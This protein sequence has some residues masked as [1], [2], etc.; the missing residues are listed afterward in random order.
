LTQDRDLA[1]LIEDWGASVVNHVISSENSDKLAEYSLH[2]ARILAYR[3]L[4]VIKT[5][6][7][8]DMLGQELQQSVKKSMPLRP[9]QIIE[10]INDFIFGAKK[11]KPNTQDYYNPLNSYLNIVLERRT[12]I[13][14]TL[15]ILYIQIAKA[16]NFKLYP[17]NFPAHFL[18]KHVME[19][20]NG[21]I[22]IDPF[23]GG[24]IMDDYALKSLLDQFYPRQNIPMTHAF[25][26]KATAAQVITRM[27]NNLKASYYEAQDI[28]RAEIS[29]EMV[30]AI[31]KYNPDGVRDKGMILLKKGRSAEALKILNSY[32]EL[33]PNAND[34]D[35]ILDIIRQ[36]RAES[37]NF[38]N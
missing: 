26:E 25:V 27:L 6:Q 35:A 19:G 16:L 17:V 38:G 4:D 34:A 20:D 32:L 36:I 33:D 22:I 13:P 14:I 10:K 24:R 5:I 1:S 28:D 9:T 21:E 29:N 37:N 30:L 15:S 18:V 11:F 3:D 23:N 12:G 2:L 8:I 31:D 7:E